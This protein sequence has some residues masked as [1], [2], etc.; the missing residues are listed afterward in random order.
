[1][2]KSSLIICCFGM[3]VILMS[4]F[5]TRDVPKYKNL[6]IL[7]KDITKEELDSVMHL[8]AMSLGQKCNF[9]HVR[10][11]QDK[12]WDFASDA[13]PY[14]GVARKMMLM[15]I[16]INK[17]NFSAEGQDSKLMVQAVSCYTC[18]HGEAIP[19]TRPPVRPQI[20]SLKNR[21]Q[22][23]LKDSL[24]NILPLKDSLHNFH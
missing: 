9:C 19:E 13:V 21:P 18:H 5:I 1:M 23:P 14:K 2:K 22:P 24:G 7:R 16:K 8:F 6:K 15:T 12:S 3:A 11:E 4:A 10:N 20:D 17:Q